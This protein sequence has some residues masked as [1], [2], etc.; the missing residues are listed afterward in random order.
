MREFKSSLMLQKI[1]HITIDV[2]TAPASRS[3]PVL[4]A[5]PNK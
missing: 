5:L 3:V 2:I 4:H 1:P